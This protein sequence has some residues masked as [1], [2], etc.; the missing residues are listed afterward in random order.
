VGPPEGF[1]TTVTT[2]KKEVVTAEPLQT[3]GV[4]TVTTV[5]SPKQWLQVNFYIKKQGV[6]HADR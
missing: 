4:T 3:K 2:E 6:S 1:V 5:T